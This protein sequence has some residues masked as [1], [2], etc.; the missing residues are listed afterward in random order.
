METIKKLAAHLDDKIKLRG[1]WEM[2]DGVVLEKGLEQGYQALH[3]FN[4]DLAEEFLQLAEA[5][6]KADREGMVD[7]AA[8]LGAAV[9]KLIIFKRK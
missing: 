3:R 7:E 9:L 6:M 2:I 5:Y 8:D 4:P 1:I